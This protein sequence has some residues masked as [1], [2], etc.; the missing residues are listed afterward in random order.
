MDAFVKALIERAK[1]TPYVHLDGYMNRYWLTADP[2]G[3]PVDMLGQRIHHILR[4][5]NDL[6]MHDHPF[7]SVSLILDG[8]YIER[9]PLHQLQD[10]MLDATHFLTFIRSAGDVIHRM[11]HHRHKIVKVSEGG[12]WTQFTTGHWEK[13]WGFYT[14]E[15]FVY[16][17][18]YLNQ[19]GDDPAP[20][21]V[22]FAR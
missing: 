21:E 14:P 12:V 13:K 4:A 20:G 10:P 8:Y 15:G 5:D 11:A 17:R 22:A 6:F 18:K 1:Q 3:A 2:K 7:E 9:I 16:W 19:W